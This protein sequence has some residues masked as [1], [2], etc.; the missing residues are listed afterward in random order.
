MIFILVRPMAAPTDESATMVFSRCASFSVGIRAPYC[1]FLC[2][3]YCMQCF[4]RGQGRNFWQSRAKISSLKP[5]LFCQ[6]AGR[7]KWWIMNKER[8]M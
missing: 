4:K 2:T 1:S 7:E 8:E 5:A 6:E 3:L